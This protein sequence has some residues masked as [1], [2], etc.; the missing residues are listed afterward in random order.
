MSRQLQVTS[1]TSSATTSNVTW[2]YQTP[3]TSRDVNL[4]T[5]A[6]FGSPSRSQSAPFL[7]L[8]PL[9]FNLGDSS[10]TSSKLFRSCDW[11]LK[12]KF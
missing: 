5:A 11:D 3:G 6:R 1:S 4:N 10:G 9:R 2:T 7:G 8:S 12:I